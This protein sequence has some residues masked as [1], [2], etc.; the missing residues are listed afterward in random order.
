LEYT[1]GNKHIYTKSNITINSQPLPTAT[2]PQTF[3]IQERQLSMILGKPKH[4]MV[5]L[6]LMEHFIDHN[7]ITN[8]A[9]MPHHK[10]LRKRNDTSFDQYSKYSCKTGSAKSNILHK[11]ES[12]LNTI[13]ISGTALQWYN[14]TGSLYSTPLRWCDVLCFAKE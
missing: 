2:S 9:L 13:V 3:C 6:M 8:G 12:T 4:K 7:F 5:L 10:R 1:D 11:S 14:S